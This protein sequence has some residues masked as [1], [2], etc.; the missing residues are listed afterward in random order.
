[1]N[2]S[3]NLGISANTK[4]KSERESGSSKSDKK[5][6]KR[7]NTA[8][9][10]T[11]KKTIRKLEAK[12]AE[13][14]EKY[15]RLAAEFEN[16]KKMTSR[17]IETKI[18]RVQE[19]MILDILSVKDDLDRTLSAVGDSQEKDPVAQGVEL[20]HS[21]VKKIL[22]SYGVE[23]IDSIGE[24]FNVEYHEALMMVEDDNYP[25]NVIVQ[26]HQKGYK[27]NGRVLRHAKVA[28]NK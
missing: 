1:M 7:T 21:H 16:Y 14:S 15:L 12:N 6:A 27:I 28:V 20:I 24:E 4:S 10:N 9:E 22:E 3:E 26:E 11:L 18:E 17:D 5:T 2:S 13:L 19:R 23:E 25:A 8:K